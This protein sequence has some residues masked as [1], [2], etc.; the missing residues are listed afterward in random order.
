MGGGG[1]T[2]SVSSAAAPEAAEAPKAYQQE[3]EMT[4]KAQ[5]ARDAQNKRAMAALGQ[6]GSILTTP[7]GSQQQQTSQQNKN[8]LG[9]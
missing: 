4:D 2:P 8:L 5:A 6:Q 7:F 9:G 3:Q 1:K